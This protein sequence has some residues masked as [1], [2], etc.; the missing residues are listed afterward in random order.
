MLCDSMSAAL[1]F[2]RGRSR[3]YKMLRQTR[4]LYGH[5]LLW[6]I[7]VHFRWVPSELNPADGPSR[8]SSKVESKTL[9]RSLPLNGAGSHGRDW[10]EEGP[11]V[12]AGLRCSFTASQ[13]K[14]DPATGSRG[15]R[16]LAKDTCPSGSGPVKRTGQQATTEAGSC[17]GEPPRRQASGTHSFVGQLQ[18]HF[19]APRHETAAAT[20]HQ[21]VAASCAKVCVRDDGVE[22]PGAVLVREEGGDRQD[23][24][25][26]HQGVRGVHN[27]RPE[28]VGLLSE[29]HGCEPRGHGRGVDEA[30]QRPLHDGSS[31]TSRGQGACVS[32]APAPG[33]QQAGGKEAAPCVALPERVAALSPGTVKTG[34]SAGGLGC[35]LACEFRRMHQLRMAIFLL[36]GLSSYARP[37][38][39]LRCTVACLVAP[40]KRVTD[41]WSL[42]LNPEE[43]GTP[44]KVGEYD[45]SVLLDSA[46]LKPW[47]PRLFR[48][49]VQGA[50]NRPLWDF[51][52]SDFLSY[53]NQAAARLQLPVTPY[54]WRHSGPS[55]DISRRLRTLTEVQKRGRWKSQKSVTR[56][57]KSGRLAMNFNGLPLKVQQHCLE[58]ES[59]PAPQVSYAGVGGLGST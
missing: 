54:Q 35:P 58:A 2:E 37:S 9:L 27:L 34:V 42:V 36:L 12:G 56:Y 43:S 38:E 53:F 13:A 6:D 45:D 46:W 14:Q 17:C 41:H 20:P 28:D 7:D 15:Q 21:A 47:A 5:A 25:L 30:L 29:G 55:I 50:G 1:A 40:S 18:Q 24:G 23:G 31:R 16:R 26:L 49:L 59:A 4:K 52:Y 44:S 3:N 39:L 32:H 22:G 19:G 11:D 48:T 57:E 33:L 10:A 51:E 8:L